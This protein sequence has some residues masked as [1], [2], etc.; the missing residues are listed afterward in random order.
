MNT[1]PSVAPSQRPIRVLIVDDSEIVRS[2]LS[3]VLFASD[4]TQTVGEAEHGQDAV[5]LCA[6]LQPDLVLM[7]LVMP[8]MDG[9]Q[10][11][12]LIHAAHPQIKIMAVTSFGDE[13]LVHGALEAGATS[14]L[15]KTVSAEELTKAIRATYEGQATIHPDV[16]KLVRTMR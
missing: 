5:R 7:D 10:A 16:V 13:H 3:A 11:I 1:I 14:Y 6:E 8:G 9:V 4:G 2:A 12:R 15:L